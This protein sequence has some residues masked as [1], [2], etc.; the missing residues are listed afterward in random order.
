VAELTEAWGSAPGRLTLEL[1]ESALIEPA[2]R[3]SFAN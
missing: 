2:P 1:T 3:D